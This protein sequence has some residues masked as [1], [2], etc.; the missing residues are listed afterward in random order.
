[1]MARL[2]HDN[3]ASTVGRQR[4]AM[5][6]WSGKWKS[7]RTLDLREPSI[8]DQYATP[9]HAPEISKSTVGRN[10][11]KVLGQKVKTPGEDTIR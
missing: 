3:R 5:F 11:R 4:T 2:R 9:N 7:V 8:D 10:L 1:M 6:R